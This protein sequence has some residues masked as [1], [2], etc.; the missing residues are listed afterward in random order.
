VARRSLKTY[1]AIE[2]LVVACVEQAQ[3][4]GDID[5]SVDARELGRLLLSVERG[6]EALGRAGMDEASL[7]RIAEAALAAAHLRPSGR[8]RVR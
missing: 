1:R 3:R 7:R 6:I 8:S 5:S 4:G 2:D